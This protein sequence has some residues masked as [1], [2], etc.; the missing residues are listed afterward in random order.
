MIDRRR[1]HPDRV[2]SLDRL[3]VSRPPFSRAN[4]AKF[5]HIVRHLRP[6]FKPPERAEPFLRATLRIC[7]NGQDA[8]ALK[9]VAGVRQAGRSVER[10]VRC[11]EPT[12]VLFDLNLSV[13]EH[14]NRLNR[15][16]VA[17]A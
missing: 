7:D 16:S 3:V 11:G 4:A 2:R 6:R 1:K 5:A 17:S 8:V 10:K 13:R 15:L 14:T 9:P 12:A